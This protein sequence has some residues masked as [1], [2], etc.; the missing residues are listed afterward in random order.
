MK[1]TLSFTNKFRKERGK[2]K[3][4]VPIVFKIMRSRE[5]KFVWLHIK[6]EVLYNPNFVKISVDE[7]HDLFEVR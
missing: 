3:N 2:S 5:K 1:V 7:L 4:L 6:I